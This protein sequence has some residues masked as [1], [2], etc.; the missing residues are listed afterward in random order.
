MDDSQLFAKLQEVA[1]EISD[2]HVSILKF[3]TN[4]RVSFETP[5]DRD[6]IREMAVGRTFAEAARGAL[7][8]VGRG[9]A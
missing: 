6:D 4:W 9:I 5:N 8:R 7:D 3:T 1:E 2:G